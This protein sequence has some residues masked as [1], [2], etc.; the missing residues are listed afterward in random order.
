[1]NLW[2]AV[3]RHRRL[4]PLF[5]RSPSVGAGTFVAPSASVIGSVTIGKN[6][7][8]WY[9]AVLRGASVCLCVFGD[10]ALVWRI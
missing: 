5:D 6:S 2:L 7:A 9:G 1:M 10:R 8:V 3:S 4:M